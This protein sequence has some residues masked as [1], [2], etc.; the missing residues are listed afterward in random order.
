MTAES[1]VSCEAQ[2]Y[3]ERVS[4]MSVQEACEE[5]YRLWYDF[6]RLNLQAPEKIRYRVEKFGVFNDSVNEEVLTYLEAPTDVYS[7]QKGDFLTNGQK[8]RRDAEIAAG[9]RPGF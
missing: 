8:I 5:W 6:S 9:T 3:G 1:P 4:R 7:H 2:L